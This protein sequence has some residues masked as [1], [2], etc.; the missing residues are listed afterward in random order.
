MG[1]FFH[2][3]KFIFCSALILYGYLM[4]Y[5]PSIKKSFDNNFKSLATLHPSLIPLK[6]AFPHLD[7][8]RV[9]FG[10]INLL[11]V[12]MIFSSTR[13]IPS[14]LTL[15]LSLFCAV[16]NNPFLVKNDEK[17]KEDTVA[18][19]L[20]TIALIGGLLYLVSCGKCNKCESFKTSEKGKAK[21]E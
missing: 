7:Y 18:R 15:S 14:I 16:V 21:T 20:K 2:L 6:E 4:I 10:A 12:F 8:I 9:G 1:F 19:L 11:A 17:L 3:G 5:D 13:C